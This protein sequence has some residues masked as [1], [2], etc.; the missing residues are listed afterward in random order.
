MVQQSFSIHSGSRRF[1]YDS[2]MSFFHDTCRKHL[3]L[4]GV[5]YIMKLSQLLLINCLFFILN[6]RNFLVE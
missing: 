2:R 1:S 5:T 3:S 6:L 4:Y